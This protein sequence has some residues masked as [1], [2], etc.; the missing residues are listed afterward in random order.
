[1]SDSATPQ[2]AANQAPRPWASPGNKYIKN[3]LDRRVQGS[4]VFEYSLLQC[5][6][7]Y[8]KLGQR[9]GHWHQRW[10]KTNETFQSKSNHQ[11]T[12]FSNIWRKRSTCFKILLN[13]TLHRHS[14]MESSRPSPKAAITQQALGI[15]YTWFLPSMGMGLGQPDVTECDV[16]CGRGKVPCSL[17][18]M[19]GEHIFRTTEPGFLSGVLSE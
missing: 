2:T 12:Y 15:Q 14:F 13:Q 7:M 9:L 5:V 1:M 8:R 10:G 6:L 18:N 11:F 19:L 4:Q 3:K 17:C 16:R